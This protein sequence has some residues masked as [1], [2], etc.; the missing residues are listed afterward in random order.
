MYAVCLRSWQQRIDALLAARE[1][2]AALTL[3]T[4]LYTGRTGRLGVAGNGGRNELTERVLAV[5]EQ[6][7][8]RAM[9]TDL[10][11]S[12]VYDTLVEHYKR[13]V[14]AVVE[15]LVAFKRTS[16]LYGTVGL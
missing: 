5:C 11:K 2:T 13:I 12:L 10:P 6:L 8:D 7:I 14:P 15:T 1:N 9:S 16:V 4:H 3:A